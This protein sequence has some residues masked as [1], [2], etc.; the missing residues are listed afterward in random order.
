ME[1]DSVIG[2][3]SMIGDEALFIRDYSS[4]CSTPNSCSDWIKSRGLQKVCRD[5]RSREHPVSWPSHLNTL[6]WVCKSWCQATG[7]SRVL[8]EKVHCQKL[9]KPLILY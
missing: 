5:P 2:D 3:T 4:G 8:H 9:V 7:K 6:H 1:P